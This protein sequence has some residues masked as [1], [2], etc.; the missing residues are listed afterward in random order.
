MIQND[1]A[2]PDYGLGQRRAY[3]LRSLAIDS[4]VIGYR[5]QF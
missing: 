3:V 2:L 1:A 4:P 5:A